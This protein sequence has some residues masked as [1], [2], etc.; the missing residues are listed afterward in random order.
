[1]A[2]TLDTPFSYGGHEHRA[3]IPL[4][5]CRIKSKQLQK[6]KKKEK[7]ENKQ[8]KQKTKQNKN[9]WVNSSGNHNIS[10]T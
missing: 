9:T 4:P 7:K 5:T 3:Y 1:M 10:K 2:T 8:N 6:K